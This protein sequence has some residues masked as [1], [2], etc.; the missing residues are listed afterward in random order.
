MPSVS[1]STYACNYIDTPNEQRFIQISIPPSR[2]IPSALVTRGRMCTDEMFPFSIRDRL[3]RFENQQTKDPS[4]VLNPLS[5]QNMF[6]AKKVPPIPGFKLNTKGT[7]LTVST[8]LFPARNSVQFHSCS[9]SPPPPA[10]SPASLSPTHVGSSSL[11][12]TSSPSPPVIVA[13]IGP[14]SSSSSGTTSE[15][16]TTLISNSNLYRSLSDKS[17][18]P[19]NNLPFSDKL[20]VA[21]RLTAL[22][23]SS[24][25]SSSSTSSSSVLN[26]SVEQVGKGLPIL[27][28]MSIALGSPRRAPGD[29]LLVTHSKDNNCEVNHS[30]QFVQTIPTLGKTVQLDASPTIQENIGA[31]DEGPPSIPKEPKEGVISSGDPGRR[32]KTGRPRKRRLTTA[33]GRVSKIKRGRCDSDSDFN[34]SWPSRPRGK[35]PPLTLGEQRRKGG[36]RRSA[37]N[38]S[39]QPPISTESSANRRYLDSPFLCLCQSG[40]VASSLADVAERLRVNPNQSSESTSLDAVNLTASLSAHVIS[41]ALRGISCV[42]STQTAPLSIPPNCPLNVYHGGEHLAR[43]DCSDP[44]ETRTIFSGLT[45]RPNSLLKT[46]SCSTTD[47]PSDLCWVCAFCGKDSNFL[48]IGSL[49]GPY[50][51]TDSERSQLPAAVVTQRV[52]PDPVAKPA[53]GKSSVNEQHAKS[54]RSG[55]I[56]STVTRSAAAQGKSTVANTGT[57]RLIIKSRSGSRS[58]ASRCSAEQPSSEPPRVGIDGEVWFHLEC[59]LWA[60][61]TYIIG[62]GTIAGLGDALQLAL[63]SVCSNCDKRGAILN[64]AHHGCDLR[65]HYLCAVRADCLLNEEQYTLMCK[66]HGDNSRT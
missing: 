7:E 5:G 8:D 64:C 62:N 6:F 12:Q 60:P 21:P 44:T 26:D 35:A 18:Q 63:D 33:G 56:T 57:L 66:M 25:S 9:C 2:E 23:S 45:Y 10:L 31:T 37:P 17:V 15:R 20:T 59:V 19:G 24:S 38:T 28:K 41:P 42:G 34:N 50:Y 29:Q 65:Y 14:H 30:G 32:P 61:G 47:N 1:V 39:A 4:L 3:I 43:D 36:N 55:V 49:Y 27:E 54:I 11:N 16:T 51:L 48:E 52:L 13:E 22:S 58:S 53:P 40:T 46:R